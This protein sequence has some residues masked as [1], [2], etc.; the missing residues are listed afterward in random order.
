MLKMKLG[1]T[2]YLANDDR[3]GLVM[4]HH[5]KCT[6]KHRRVKSKG[7]EKRD[8]PIYSTGDSTAD[9]VRAYESIN[10][11]RKIMAWDWL[12]LRD[13]PCLA[14]VGVDSYEEIDHASD[15]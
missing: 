1:K 6:G 4:A 12:Q 15:I 7:A 11:K 10:V 13:A 9:Y 5:V 3:A 2:I 14:P 8:Y